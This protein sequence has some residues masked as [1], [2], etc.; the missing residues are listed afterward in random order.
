MKTLLLNLIALLFV[1]Q[2]VLSQTTRYVNP[3]G[4]GAN[5]PCYST[6]QA[7]INASVSGDIIQVAS[8][9]Y[10]EAL[11]IGISL[12]LEGVSA[13][14]TI[15]N[16]SGLNLHTISITAG[17]LKIRKFCIKE[18]N[19]NTKSC[20]YVTG[21]TVNAGTLSDKGLNQF[22]VFGTGSAIDNEQAVVLNAIGNYWG[23]AK[24]PTISTNYC[25]N[26]GAITGTGASYVSYSPWKD[27]ELFSNDVTPGGPV[28]TV[29]SLNVCAGTTTVDIPITVSSFTNVGVISLKL[30]YDATKLG[31]A[32]LLSQQA[33]LWGNFAVNTATSGTILVS[34]YGTGITLSGTPTLFTLR[35]TKATPITNGTLTFV[36]NVQGTSCEYAPDAPPLYAPLS[37]LYMLAGELHGPYYNKRIENSVIAFFLQVLVHQP[38][39][40][41]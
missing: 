31:S 19:A 30:A 22:L 21:G 37:L 5:S 24:G 39:D 23:S 41:F 38:L 35:F 14:T 33:A 28:T 27:D 6:I 26:G 34:G 16:A 40:I 8:G 29:P 36:E 1:T 13:G 12:D 4:C 10:N 9:T 32:A 17:T 25:G 20:L 11:T 7:A 3:G 2:S 18:D 15:I